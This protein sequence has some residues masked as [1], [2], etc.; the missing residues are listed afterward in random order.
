MPRSAPKAAHLMQS[1]DDAEAQFY[2]AMREADIDKM[3]A[4]WHD[5]DEVVCVHPSGTRIV[6]P[7]AIR[8]SF[9]AI[10]ANGSIPVTPDGVRR[11]QSLDAAM[12]NLVERFTVSSSEEPQTGSVLATNVYLKTAQGWRMVLHH[13]SPGSADEPAD[14]VDVPSTLH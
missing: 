14:A 11:V 4:V 10:F 9:E 8:A 5:D 1:A 2:E 13:A 6:G 3:M 12:H 7:A